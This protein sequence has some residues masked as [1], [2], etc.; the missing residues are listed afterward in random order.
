MK[1]FIIFMLLVI[2]IFSLGCNRYSK[3]IYNK[4]PYSSEIAISNGD[5]VNV[6][7]KQHNVEKLDKFI[8]N[9][10]NGIKDKVRITHYTEE[11]DALIRDLEFDGEEIK[12][13]FDNTRDVF[14]V[15]FIES[16]KFNAD[17]IYKSDYKYYL[18]NS[19]NDILIY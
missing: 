17:S 19:S 15:P 11:G 12:Y 6:Q 9:V 14:G 10:Q 4:S 3:P 16:K 7:G 2:M 13:T 5:V 8:M 1:K 18:K